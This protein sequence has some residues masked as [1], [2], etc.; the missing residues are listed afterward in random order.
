VND[1]L[2]AFGYQLIEIHQQ[3]R[4]DLADLLEH[5][6]PGLPQHCLAFCAAIRSHHTSEDRNAFARLA[7]TDPTLRPMIELLERDHHQ[8]AALLRNAEE[9]AQGV[10]QHPE[11]APRLRG[12]LEGIAAVLESHFAFEE[13]TIVSALNDLDPTARS[14]VELFGLPRPQ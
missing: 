8:I 14:T 2:L 11:A 6:T 3:L 7:E 9:L 4:E 1:R 12:E 10:A 13:K 5:R